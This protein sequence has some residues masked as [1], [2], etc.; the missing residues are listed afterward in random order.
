MSIGNGLT[1]PINQLKYGDYLYQ[2]G[3]IDGNG[4]QIFQ[5]YEEQATNYIQNNQFIKAF[6]IFDELLNGDTNN[7]SSEFKNITGFDNYFNF[8]YP[9]SPLNTE[10]L[11]MGKYLQRLDIRQ[12]IH[13][14][15]TSFN[16]ENQI[17]EVIF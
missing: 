14:G 16:T 13:V 7:H 2:L 10:I 9:V 12:C 4:R 1:D 5:S 3:L 11:L 6:Q 17:V 15:N 8:L